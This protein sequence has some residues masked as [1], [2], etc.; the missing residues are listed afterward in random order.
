MRGTG[1]EVVLVGWSKAERRMIAHEYRR[2]EN[3]PHVFDGY[4]IRDK[5][6][7]A[8]YDAR[9]ASMHDPRTSGDMERLARAQ[10]V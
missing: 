4:M 7:I 10:M 9:F 6:H 1:Q 8:P 2:R 3:E 5:P